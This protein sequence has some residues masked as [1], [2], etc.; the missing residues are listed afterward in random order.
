V[1]LAVPMAHLLAHTHYGPYRAHH[2]HF[3]AAFVL[4]ALVLLCTIGMRDYKAPPAGS[5]TTTTTS[6]P[7]P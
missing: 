3:L 1:Q 5:S 2:V 6:A 4:A 7:R